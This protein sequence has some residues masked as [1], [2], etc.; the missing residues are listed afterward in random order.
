MQALH[1]ISEE[2]TKSSPSEIFKLFLFYQ[3]FPF[4]AVQCWNFSNVF[5]HATGLNFEYVS[6]PDVP[7]VQKNPHH[8]W[9][10]RTLQ[11]VYELMLVNFK[12]FTVLIIYINLKENPINTLCRIHM[13]THHSCAT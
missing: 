1:V 10:S 11:N 4:I 12:H 2:L 13:C 7:E 6:P 3:L 9:H 5:L 8:F